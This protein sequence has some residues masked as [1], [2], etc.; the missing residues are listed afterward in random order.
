M[1]LRLTLSF[2]FFVLLSAL[3]FGFDQ[4]GGIFSPD[5]VRFVEISYGSS[6]SSFRFALI[7]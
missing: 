7:D 3:L 5:L 2:I 4:N 1:D 6:I